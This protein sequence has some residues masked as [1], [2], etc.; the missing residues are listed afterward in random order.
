M[1]KD[2]LKFQTVDEYIMQFPVEIQETLQQLRFIIKEAAP[3]AEEIISYQMPA[4]SLNGTLVYF[5]VWKNHIGFYPTSSG[6]NAFKNEL[7]PYKGTKS[8][9]HFSFTKPLPSEL[10]SRIVKFRVAENKKKAQDE[11]K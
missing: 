3:E 1:E 8:S 10:I 11:I 9:V 2:K 7:S 6:M 5:A 4:F